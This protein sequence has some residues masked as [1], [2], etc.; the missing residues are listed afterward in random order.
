MSIMAEIEEV[1]ARVTELPDT[2]KFRY[3]KFSSGKD[4]VVGWYSESKRKEVDRLL[5]L[6]KAGD[7]RAKYTLIYTHNVSEL[8]LN[9]QTII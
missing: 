4:H 1:A 6:A 3:T 8:T 7:I 5:K 2:K 9:H